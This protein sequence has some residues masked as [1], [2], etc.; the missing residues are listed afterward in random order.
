[1]GEMLECDCSDDL[2]PLSKKCSRCI[3]LYQR[4]NSLNERFANM[5]KGDP[6]LVL[7][8]R[9]ILVGNIILSPNIHSQVEEILYDN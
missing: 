2:A 6:T 4:A 8:E 1:M 7:N 3:G 9:D 5:D